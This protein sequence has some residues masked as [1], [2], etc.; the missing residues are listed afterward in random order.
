M[1]TEVVGEIAR[2]MS[3]QDLNNMRLVNARFKMALSFQYGK[4]TSVTENVTI[5]P[6]LSSVAAFL[7][8]LSLDGAYAGTVRKITLVGEG[9]KTPELSYDISWIH[10]YMG[11]TIDWSEQTQAQKIADVHIL[12]YVNDKHAEWDWINKPF[13]HTGGY[14]TMLSK[15]LSQPNTLQG[16]PALI[17]EQKKLTPN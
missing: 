6:T 14:R 5:F 16:P 15:S 9:P 4:S 12:D 13:C 10:L 1:P 7:I 11:H 3:V 8:G 17:Q 2:E